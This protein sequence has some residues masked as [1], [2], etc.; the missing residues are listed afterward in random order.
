[1][2]INLV[3]SPILSG[4]MD[5]VQQDRAGDPEHQMQIEKAQGSQFEDR[6][7]TTIRD[8]ASTPQDHPADAHYDTDLAKSMMSVYQGGL[9]ALVDGRY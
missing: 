4:S 5:F 8:A 7:A 6:M 1:M 9:G 2:E 3:D